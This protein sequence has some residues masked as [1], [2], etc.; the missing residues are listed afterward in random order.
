MP[1][2]KPQRFSIYVGAVVGDWLVLDPNHSRN[3]RDRIMSLVHCE[4]CG[5]VTKEVLRADLAAGRSRGCSC[6]QRQ[7]LIESRHLH[8]AAPRDA[9]SRTFRRW[10]DLRARYRGRYVREWDSFEVFLRDM[11]E[12]PLGY[13]MR[14]VDR[15]LPITPSNLRYVPKKSATRKN[16]ARDLKRQAARRVAGL[17]TELPVTQI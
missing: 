15:S 13:V 3:K 9:R 8:G 10:K 11:G 5:E 6:Y 2:R 14:V 17:A 4:R 12:L 16:V 1:R 7:L